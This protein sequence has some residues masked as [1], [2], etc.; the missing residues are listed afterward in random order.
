[1]FG[2]AKAVT[3]S[4]LILALGGALFVIQPSGRQ[5]GG[6]P[7]AEAEPVEPTWFTGNIARAPSCT[8]SDP[9]QDGAVVHDWYAECKPQ[10]WIATDPRFTGKVTA[11]WN[12]DNYEL[13]SGV[14]TVSSGAYFLQNDGGGWACSTTSLVEGSGKDSEMLTGDTIRCVG[15]GGYAGQS[16]LLINLDEPASPFVGLIFSGDFPPV[17][18]PPAEE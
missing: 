11:R 4:A 14:V 15:E 10:N 2:I 1:M 9:V 17:P 16:A 6:P 12:E 3:A 5:E 18:E 13:E 8:G 7:G